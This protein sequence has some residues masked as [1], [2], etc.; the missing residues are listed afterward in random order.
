MLRFEIARAGSPARG[1]STT[2]ASA[3]ASPLSVL[4]PRAA[5]S[6]TARPTARE[7]PQ[8]DHEL[9]QREA[10][11]VASRQAVPLPRPS[12]VDSDS[13]R[14]CRRRPGTCTS[15][16]TRNRRVAIV[17]DARSR[18]GSHRAETYGVTASPLDAAVAS[19]RV[20][21][22]P[23]SGCAAAAASER[24][25]RD[26]HRAAPLVRRRRVGERAGE[27]PEQRRGDERED[28]ERDEHLEQRE[29]ARRGGSAR[30]CASARVGVMLNRGSRHG[31]SASRRRRRTC[32]RRRRG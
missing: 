13:V 7:Q 2:A 22:L 26:E 21:R 10:A 11:V 14:G 23:R 9:D 16:V 6:R 25:L 30:A 4:R 19:C 32:A 24:A 8:R 12:A 31:R 27:E 5:A 29:A 20:G 17:S 18:S 1:A 28:H 3:L 15:T